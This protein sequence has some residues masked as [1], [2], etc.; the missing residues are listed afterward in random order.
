MTTSLSTAQ[1]R[2]FQ[3]D[4]Y[5]IVRRFFS[6]QEILLLQ[7][8]ARGDAGLVANARSL[9]DAAGRRSRLTLWNDLGDDLYGRFARCRRV[10]GGARQLLGEEVYHWHSKI[11]LKEPRT[12]GAWEWHQDFGYWH[13]HGLPAPQLVSCML[14]IDRATKANG[15]L[16]VL[17]GSHHLGRLEHGRFG[18]QTGADPAQVAAAMRRYE[19]IHFAAEPGDVLF[20]HANTLHCSGPNTSAD[21]RWAL[22]M[23]YNAL[24]N[25]PHS[26]SDHCHHMPLVA[27]DDESILAWN[28]IL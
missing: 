14:A 18:H 1:I 17:K 9:P 20:L 22:I 10:V 26:D 25:I 11:M 6:A 19:L 15:C 5:V 8:Y 2:A 16:Q 7:R 23:S 3:R 4:G 13:A 28:S 12:G 24:S 21:P 27:I